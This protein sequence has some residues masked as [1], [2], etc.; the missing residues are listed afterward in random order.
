MKYRYFVEIDDQLAE[1]RAE[2][3]RLGDDAEA[4]FKEAY[5]DHET[6]LHNGGRGPIG[7]IVVKKG[8]PIPPGWAWYKTRCHTLTEGEWPN[9]TKLLC[10][11]PDNR[12]AG[13]DVR[14]LLDRHS[15][16]WVDLMGSRLGVSRRQYDQCAIYATRIGLKNGRVM[17][18]VPVGGQAFDKESEPQC[19]KG[20]REIKHSEWIA[21]V[22]E[23]APFGEQGDSQAVAA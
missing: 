14:A 2:A 6:W 5:P 22:E 21:I 1:L 17:V 15:V 19:P 8:D 4:A 12:K 11:V 9:Y 18:A 3:D 16:S 20:M 23:G 13:D 10:L 7:G